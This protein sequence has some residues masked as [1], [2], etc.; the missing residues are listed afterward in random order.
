M[1]SA[2]RYCD[3]LWNSETVAAFMQWQSYLEDVVMLGESENFPNAFRIN[4]F[5]DDK[6]IRSHHC[7]V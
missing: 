7:S 3:H 1:G 5:L 4:N 2:A 6:T